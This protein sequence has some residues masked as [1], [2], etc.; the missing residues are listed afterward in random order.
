M[1]ISVSCRGCGRPGVLVRPGALGLVGV[2][3]LLGV[4]G[5]PGVLVRLGVPLFARVRYGPVSAAC[6]ALS[7]GD[8]ELRAARRP[9]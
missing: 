3:G 8:S 6:R 4:L 7:R 9:I 2:L 5:L 1:S